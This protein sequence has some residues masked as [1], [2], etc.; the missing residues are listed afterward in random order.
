L[1]RNV[2]TRLERL[3]TIVEQET[4]SIDGQ[5]VEV[6][7]GLASLRDRLGDAIEFRKHSH[8]GPAQNEDRAN[9]ADIASQ[10]LPAYQDSFKETLPIWITT[11][12]LKAALYGL[13][14]PVEDLYTVAADEPPTGPGGYLE[15]GKVVRAR[16]RHIA[17][18]VDGSQAPPNGAAN[19]TIVQ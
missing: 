3:L 1:A 16:F 12:R 19:E 10:L 13:R 14:T 7:D 4:E 9:L 5:F 2:F 8:P 6:F 11:P 17:A 15:D 18:T